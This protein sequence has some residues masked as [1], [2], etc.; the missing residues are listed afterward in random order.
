MTRAHNSH[1]ATILEPSLG[2][3]I[4]G[5]LN[6]DDFKYPSIDGRIT[7]R[8]GELKERLNPKLNI[9]L[10]KYYQHLLSRDPPMN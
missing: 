2:G 7:A 8:L 3:H 4:T 6:S 5:R 9:R 10:S 1:K